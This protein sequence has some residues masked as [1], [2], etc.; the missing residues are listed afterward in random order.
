MCIWA[1]VGSPRFREHDIHNRGVNFDLATLIA[2]Q[3]S[4][5]FTNS[6]PGLF[7][8]GDPGIPPALTNGS[9]LDFAPRIGAA[10]DPRG[11]GK[12]SVRVSYGIFFDLPES[13]TDG[14]F[15]NSSPW[16]SNITLAAPAGGFANP[17]LGIAGRQSLSFASSRPPANATFAQAG[18][19]ITFP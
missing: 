7:F 16:G 6:P 17:Y 19:Y 9:Y 15:G 13:Y 10:W 5:V 3:K 1:C 12:E 18:T 11:D 2:G 8:H 14:D 4:T